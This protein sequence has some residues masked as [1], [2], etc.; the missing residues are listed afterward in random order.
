MVARYLDEILTFHRKRAADDSRDLSSLVKR[1]SL[2]PETRGFRL[3]LAA[4][5]TASGQGIAVI[6]EFKRRSPSKG[7]LGSDLDVVDIC[8][9]YAAGGASCISVLTDHEFFAGAPEDL[10]AAREVVDLPVLRKDF[11]VSKADVCDARIMGADAVLLIVAA[12][13]RTELVELCTLSRDLGMDSLVEVHDTEELDLA[14]EIGADLIGVNQ[15][16]LRTFGVHEDRARKLGEAIP[17][18]VTSVAESGI[19]SAAG[20]ASAAGAGFDAIIVGEALIRSTERAGTLAELR[21]AGAG[22]G[23]V[24]QKR[25]QSPCL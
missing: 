24:A 15:R 9:Q 8:R 20:A 25:A 17:E 11:T 12:L 6:A 14:L 7:V 22:L 5:G 21:S 2:L 23:P 18:E 13:S 4:E 16:D 1:A 19:S 3:S 10:Q